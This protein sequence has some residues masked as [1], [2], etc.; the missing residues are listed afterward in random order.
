M[1]IITLITCRKHGK[2]INLWTMRINFNLELEQ[3]LIN[4]IK[5][6][7]GHNKHLKSTII[8]VINFELIK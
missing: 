3:I 5:G 8:T 7:N 4:I 1:P 2:E 6:K